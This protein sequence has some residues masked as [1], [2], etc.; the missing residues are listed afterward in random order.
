[1]EE[2]LELIITILAFMLLSFI[3]VSIN[4]VVLEIGRE[5][6]KEGKGNPN[7][8]KLVIFFT[9]VFLLFSYKQ[10][11]S[12]RSYMKELK[13]SIVEKVENS[14]EYLLDDLEDDIAKDKIMDS[15]KELVEEIEF[16]FDNFKTSD[17][18]DYDEY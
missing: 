12:Q 6:Q 9:I 17:Y 2:V 14:S 8:I 15:T 3:F 10:D 7:I 11:Y 16:E 13:E 5:H 1:M 18:T 4:S